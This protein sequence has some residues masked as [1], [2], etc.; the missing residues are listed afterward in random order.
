MGKPEYSLS[1][2]VTIK[3]MSSIK[4]MSGIDAVGISVSS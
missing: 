3:K 1:T 4:I 2:V